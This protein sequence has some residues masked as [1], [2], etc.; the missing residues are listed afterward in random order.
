MW[1]PKRG[2]PEFCHH[3]P[4]RRDNIPIFWIYRIIISIFGSVSG[5]VAKMF[6]YFQSSASSSVLHASR[7][8]KTARTACFLFNHTA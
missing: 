8:G 4:Y 5:V 2:S 3:A 6:L 1:A 7:L